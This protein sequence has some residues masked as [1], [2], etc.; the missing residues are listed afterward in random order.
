MYIKTWYGGNAQITYVL[1]S[2]LGLRKPFGF[3]IIEL[4]LK[5]SQNYIL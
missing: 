3:S 1:A 5:L 4:K 2:T